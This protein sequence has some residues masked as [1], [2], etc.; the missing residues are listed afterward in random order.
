MATK[1]RR[2]AK[3]KLAGDVELVAYMIDVEADTID[4]DVPASDL[5]HTSLEF[6]PGQLPQTT[7]LHSVATW[8]REIAEHLRNMR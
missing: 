7:F 3:D 4:E 8:L 5:A 1:K 2:T 6:P